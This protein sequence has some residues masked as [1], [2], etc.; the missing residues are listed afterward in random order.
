[1]SS[2]HI[3]TFALAGAGS[4]G[5]MFASWVFD[6]FGP[7]ALV[8]I[9]EPLEEH[10]TAI[11]EQHGIPADRRFETWQQMLEGRRYADILLNTT[12]DLDHVGSA[13]A[14]LDLGYHMLLEKP[15]ATTL[16]D[17]EKI[18]EHRRRSGRI[19]SVCHSLR[20]HRAYETTH[21]LIRSGAIGDIVSLDQL[22]AVQ[23]VHQSHSFVRGNWNRQETSTFMLLAKSCHDLD[24]IAWLIDKPCEVVSSYGGLTHFRAENAP[25]QAPRFC[26]E[27]CPVEDTCP[28]HAAK[29]YCDTDWRFSAGLGGLSRREIMEELKTS[30]F[31]RC[32]YRCDNDAVDHQ[33]VAMRF[34]GGVTATFTMTAFTPW[35]GRYVRIHGTKGYIEMKHDQNRIDMWEFWARNRHTAI[36]VPAAEGVHGGGDDQVIRHL[37]DAVS[38]NDASRIRTT[39]H[40]S[41]RTHKIVFAAEMSR[42]E[43]RS[44]RLEELDS[45]VPARV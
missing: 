7:G 29:I 12:M 33:V 15:L 18:D 5:R 44:V 4:R 2:P 34:A 41:L 32:V 24:A 31:G 37:V 40:E 10:R 1:M 42:T 36:E 28:Y 14:A 11:A 8:A 27:G 9:A 16:A 43:G 35:G 20:Y 26:V 6:A 38:R 19:V 22:E 23:H 17:A 45:Q 3:P 13:C 25:P 39:T 30:R 21:E